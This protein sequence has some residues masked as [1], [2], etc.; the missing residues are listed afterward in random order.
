MIPILT[1]TCKDSNGSLTKGWFRKV[2]EDDGSG[3]GIREPRDLNIQFWKKKRFN[4]NLIQ[5]Q[6]VWSD[7]DD[8][9]KFRTITILLG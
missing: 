4:N 1:S 7:V 2:S 9:F 3:T 6:S 8:Y 5:Q